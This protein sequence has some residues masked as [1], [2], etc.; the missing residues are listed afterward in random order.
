M[1]IAARRNPDRREADV[2]PDGLPVNTLYDPDFVPLDPSQQGHQQPD[3]NNH[4][5]AN[6]QEF[7]QQAHFAPESEMAIPDASVI[8]SVIAAGFSSLQQEA[9]M[10]GDAPGVPDAPMM[11]TALEESASENSGSLNDDLHQSIDPNLRRDGPV[12][13]SAQV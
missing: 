7:N 1:V 9:D 4:Q 11:S 2:G 12:P 3:N 6:Q 10:T 8:G 5:D 13:P